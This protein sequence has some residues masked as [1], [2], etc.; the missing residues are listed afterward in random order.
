MPPQFLTQW[1][2]IEGQQNALYDACLCALLQS[3]ASMAAAQGLKILRAPPT[4]LALSCVG[5]PDAAGLVL[6]CL[7]AL[8]EC[9]GSK[10]GAAAPLA[11]LTRFTYFYTCHQ[12]KSMQ[13]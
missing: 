2:A 7:L 3:V 9:S 1:R 10:S 5:H 12:F 13:C 8:P 4:R 6:L 11:S